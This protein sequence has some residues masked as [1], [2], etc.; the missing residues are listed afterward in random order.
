MPGGPYTGPYT[1]IYMYICIRSPLS[2]DHPHKGLG[3]YQ[4]VFVHDPGCPLPI[5]QPIVS[6][7]LSGVQLVAT[8]LPRLFTNH[9]RSLG[10]KA[11]EQ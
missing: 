11:S 9:N 3:M 8:S 7:S 10:P 6:G 2:I 1:Y 5:N 4:H